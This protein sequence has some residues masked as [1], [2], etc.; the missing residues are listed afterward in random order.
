MV[1]ARKLPEASVWIKATFD[2]LG[3]VPLSANG[4]PLVFKPALPPRVQPVIPV[5]EATYPGAAGTASSSKLGL[6]SCAAFAE[7]GGR[8]MT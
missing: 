3:I 7:P 5:A 1:V 8:L 2:P 4:P 6:G